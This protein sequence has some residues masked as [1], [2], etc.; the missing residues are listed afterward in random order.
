[1]AMAV[2]TRIQDGG[3]M[4]ISAPGFIP[5][6]RCRDVRGVITVFKT[7]VAA[8]KQIV[9]PTPF[10]YVAPNVWIFAAELAQHDLVPNKPCWHYF[11]WFV[12]VL[13]QG[14]VG[15]FGAFQYADDV[16]A[17]LA[18]RELLGESKKWADFE[19]D[20][21]PNS[22]RASLSL[23]GHRA[24]EIAV[25]RDPAGEPDDIKEIF[26]GGQVEAP[27]GMLKDFNLR[28]LPAVVPGGAPHRQVVVNAL[29][30]E[31]RF[32][33]ARLESLS[34]PKVETD[35]AWLAPEGLDRFPTHEILATTYVQGA[36]T[37]GQRPGLE[38]IDVP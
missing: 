23:H 27:E 3:I 24:F 19:F 9:D 15:K 6:W 22:V 38:L 34:F 4:P 10:E 14:R 18:G 11:A 32:E 28:T 5:T 8:V 20:E 2:E 13:F 31:G 35:P 7:D 37:N 25:Q 33:A 1:M 16:T 29:E 26:L 12:P 21:T 36:F 17:I 30:L